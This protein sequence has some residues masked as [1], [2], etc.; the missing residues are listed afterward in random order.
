[1]KRITNHWADP[2]RHIDSNQDGEINASDITAIGQN[3]EAEVFQYEI[4]LFDDELDEYLTVGTL[5]LE[6]MGANA[7]E[8]VRFSYTFGPQYVEKGWYR[9]SSLSRN[10]ERGAPSEEISEVGRRLAATDVGQGR[11]VT[12][13]V[14]VTD[15]QHPIAHLN[16]LRV[17]YPE[18]YFYVRDSANAGSLGGSRDASDGIW[19]SFAPAL[20]FPNDT[21]FVENDLGDGKVAIDFNVTTL[22]RDLD[23]APIGHGDLINFQLESAGD[24]PLTLEFH[25]SSD[26]GNIKR[27]Y[28]TDA[29]DNEYYF[30]NTIG[31][32]I[33]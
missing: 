21:F 25:D 32:T 18:S 7:G 1:M 26:N 5:R 9:V 24:D 19:A 20:L 30:G 17:V 31:F 3:Y 27:T 10:L 23:G 8:T 33:Q 28:Y 11:K 4:E 29:S 13:T 6:D 15:L 14:S 12:V 16:S 2:L 22:Q